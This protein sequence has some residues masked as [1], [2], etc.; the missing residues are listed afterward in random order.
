MAAIV[1]RPTDIQGIRIRVADERWTSL[2]KVYLASNAQ[3]FERIKAPS[4]GGTKK[5]SVETLIEVGAAND[6][7][8][9]GYILHDPFVMTADVLTEEVDP[10]VAQVSRAF[11]RF[12]NRLDSSFLQSEPDFL[13]DPQFFNFQN[14]MAQNAFGIDV[15]RRLIDT[16]NNAIF[17]S[18][19]L[20]QRGNQTL[21][22]ESLFGT[23]PSNIAG[24]RATWE[25]LWSFPMRVKY[26]NSDGID[27]IAKFYR[28]QRVGGVGSNRRLVTGESEMLNNNWNTRIPSLSIRR[29][30]MLP[31]ES[32]DG[33]PTAGRNGIILVVVDADSPIDEVPFLT[34]TDGPITPGTYVSPFIHPLRYVRTGVSHATVL[35]R[36]R[37]HRSPTVGMNRGGDLGLQPRTPMPTSSAY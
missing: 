29:H 14:F 5:F 34:L 11:A 18:D 20:H 19:K 37:R 27:R 35:G 28:G 30:V 16:R 26:E 8:G 36:N 33:P 15:L 10:R 32:Y 1:S 25:N 21:I 7:Y 9:E 3:G 13:A 31:S 6:L 2:S 23:T 12:E 4:S 22:E 24:L 17:R